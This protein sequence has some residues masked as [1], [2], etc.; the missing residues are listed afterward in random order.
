LQPD[1]AQL[2]SERQRQTSLQNT[3]HPAELRSAIER[4]RIAILSLTGYETLPTRV[5]VARGFLQMI[6]PDALQML[7]PPTREA[8]NEAVTA[9]GLGDEASVLLM[10]AILAIVEDWSTHQDGGGNPRELVRSWLRLW[11]GSLTW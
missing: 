4:A 2:Q 9:G 8:V 1:Q 6:D 7:R 3:D 11:H 10:K 5:V